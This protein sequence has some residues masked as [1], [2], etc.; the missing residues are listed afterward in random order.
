M[1]A[2]PGPTNGSGRLTGWLPGPIDLVCLGLG[3]WLLAQHRLFTLDTWWHL[4][5]GVET[6]ERGAI[7]TRDTLS[8][9]AAG[10]PL[11]SHA[12]GFDLLLGLLQRVGGLGLVEVSGAL[13]VAL[14]LRL[15]AHAARAL[16]ASGAAALL[17]PPALFFSAP[18]Y[19]NLRPHLASYAGLA[20]FL[21]A[22]AALRA[23]RAGPLRWT[24]LAMVAW[25]N[26]HG[27]FVLGLLFLFGL[28]GLDR[29]LA[30]RAAD[31]AGREA[32]EARSRALVRAFLLCAVAA[33]L[34][35]H[36]P[37]QFL[38]A[39]ANTPLSHPLNATVDEW[40]PP[41][42]LRVPALRWWILASLALL[43]V[44]PG[45]PPAF[46][47]LGVLGGVAVALG[48]WRNVPLLGVAVGP[49]LCAWLTRAAEFPGGGFA[50]ALREGAALPAALRRAGA[51]LG[52]G[53]L[54]G[55]LV[56]L[57]LA[58]LLRG[59]LELARPTD[60]ERTP[61]VR[62]VFPVEAARWVRAQGLKGEMLNSYAMGGYL[63]W[64]LRGQHR[65]AI[66]SRMV[67]FHGFYQGIYAQLWTGDPT[68]RQALRASGAEL[69]VLER[70]G[71]G[72]SPLPLLRQEPA[73]KAVYADD[74]AV[75]LVRAEGPNGHLPA[76]P[77]GSW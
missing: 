23:G 51:L 41:H 38:D 74:V 3:A 71:G 72:A 67:P 24:P 70:R 21:T 73:W 61:W 43:M 75:V 12:W 4:S 58:G 53:G 26:L 57:G 11:A 50:A 29:L 59:G 39:L 37:G 8:W 5:L 66:D 40:Q 34:H 31:A 54:G 47:A 60:V 14:I 48:A 16:G 32:A 65:V 2:S 45:R 76:L 77:P 42:L 30:R 22:Y 9:T 69:I 6:L 18:E 36:G 13:A 7:P 1:T 44:H 63:G 62:S 52:A 49:I 33:C 55:G 17:A 35:P 15:V 27:G 68:W 10:A 20:W 28:A 64:A 19:L 25:S 56:L 46:E